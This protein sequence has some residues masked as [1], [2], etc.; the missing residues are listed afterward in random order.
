M[1]IFKSP[2]YEN[3]SALYFLEKVFISSKNIERLEKENPYLALKQEK[4]RNKDYS[5]SGF[6]EFK[7]RNSLRYFDKLQDLCAT[8]YTCNVELGN[9]KTYEE[10][11]KNIKNL[12]TTYPNS[13]RIILP[14]VNSFD[15][16]SLSHFNETIDCA[17]LA[18]IHYLKHRVKLVF[19]AHDVR[20]EGLV[21]FI[22]IYTFFIAPI[23]KEPI[24]IEFYLSTTQNITH[25]PYYTKEIEQY[26]SI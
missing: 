15:R 1:E 2:R 13:R 16:Y 10:V 26:E 9:F 8:I 21:D 4:F 3:D 6:D 20:E 5:K 18:F 25:F 19:R 11:I 24:D 17:C 14:I 7:N 12:L 22:N 23:Y